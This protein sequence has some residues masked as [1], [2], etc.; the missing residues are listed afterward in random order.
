MK[1][2]LV[3]L[4]VF[5][6]F[7]L[8][9]AEV[10][11]PGFAFTGKEIS[12]FSIRPSFKNIT[13]S[14]SV[15]SNVETYLKQE[16]F[17]MDAGS[18]EDYKSKK[19][20]G[21]YSSGFGT[22]I[23]S[24]FVGD[25]AYRNNIVKGY[26]DKQYLDVISSYDSYYEK[27]IKGTSYD[28][29]VRLVYSFALLQT[30]SIS[31]AM[32]ILKQ[33]A[34]KGGRFAP[35][36]SDRVAAYYLSVK[37]FEELGIFADSLPAQT[38][39]SLYAWLYSLLELHRYDRLV[40]V[41]DQHAEITSKDSRFYDFYITAR[42]L[43]GGFN[44]VIKDA[45]KSTPNTI[46]LV[47][48]SY[49]IEGDRDKANDLIDKMKPSGMKTVLMAK[50]A[51]LKGDL[52]RTGELLSELKNDEDR[53]NLLFFYVGK[54]F[55]KLDIELLSQ[56]HF[57]SRI[58]ADYLK[59][60][61]GVYYL[62]KGDR[63][64][65]IRYL[66]GVIF[67]KD[68]TD[69][70]YYYR[71]LAYAP[72]DMNRAKRYFLKYIDTSSDKDKISVSRYMLSQMAY[73]NGSLDDALML[74]TTCDR[75]YCKLLRARIFLAKKNYELAWLNAEKVQ[76][77]EAALIR[78]TVL[79]NKKDYG[80]TLKQLKQVKK[81]NREADFLRMLALLKTDRLYDA[82]T[83]YN[84]YKSDNEFTKSFLEH[85]FLTGHYNEVLKFTEDRPEFSLV[86]AKSLFS[87]G[88][89]NDAAALFEAIITSGRN[90]FD[91]WN[92]LLSAFA[93]MKDND[94]FFAAAKKLTTVKRDFDKKDFLIYQTA[95]QALNLKKPKLAT[96]LLN[97]FFDTYQSSV[98]KND[99]YL[100]QGKLFRDTG[101][102]DQCL[103]DA[104]IMLANGRNDDALF[105]KGECLQAKKPKKALKIFEDM[106]QNSGR[107][108]DLAYSKLIELYKKPADILRAV[109]YF[110]DK[111]TDRY[112][113][114]L[115]VY[116]ASL[117]AK[118]LE[119]NKP[120]LDQMIADRNPNGLAAAYY[121]IGVIDYNDKQY[122]TSV[123][124]LMKSHYLFPSSKYS[125]MSVKLA[126]E[127]Y[128]KMGRDKEADIL[129]NKL[130]KMK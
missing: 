95:Q 126:I 70:A 71:G 101:R 83:V 77:D 54:D 110:K 67:N 14:F 26:L 46:G 38:P 72:I 62:E 3:F 87:I 128:K 86:R 27:K 23:S 108:R 33:I 61:A 64:N 116:L 22:S 42:Y 73:I 12:D 51:V 15:P 99:A 63:K 43:K 111:D 8:A 20:G 124:S 84:K 114:G 85:L 50:S 2:L 9:Y 60:Y 45:G 40:K 105:L 106:T 119:K 25:V 91:A 79:F 19:P 125:P 48:D 69:A 68:L 13:V 24:V 7:S 97:Y 92:G 34:K 11:I 78:A 6:I 59:Y 58:N 74:I 47:A 90:S 32:D 122:E 75:D 65:A 93:A 121:Y 127:D 100:L 117:N 80:G 104:D 118:Q 112:Y 17:K 107:F 76:G 31:Q 129:K 41:F 96:L 18:T 28:E 88:R 98:Y 44:D 66:D 1:K 115:D 102:V 16:R 57:D 53:L 4:A 103:K 10:E 113:S 94:K 123:I 82:E 36:A 81:E 30:G 56:F 89:L 21:I 49:L 109:N 39:Y 52:I 29:E 120:L 5:F 37:G 55:P 130:K 35:I